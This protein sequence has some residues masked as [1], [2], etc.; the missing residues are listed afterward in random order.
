M[1]TETT[2]YHF[3]KPDDSD[4]VDNTPLNQNFDSIGISPIPTTPTRSRKSRWDW[5]M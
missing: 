5:G 2:N 4:P 1:A 3:I